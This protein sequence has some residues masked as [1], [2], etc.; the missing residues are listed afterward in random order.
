MTISV[1]PPVAARSPALGSACKK[2]FSGGPGLGIALG[3]CW[4][5]LLLVYPQIFTQGVEHLVAKFLTS[6]GEDL[7]GNAKSA[8]P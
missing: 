3:V 4:C 1:F 5:R 7:R 6:I 8:Y 2:S